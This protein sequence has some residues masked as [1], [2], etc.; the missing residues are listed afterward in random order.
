MTKKILKKICAGT[1]LDVND[2]TPDEKKELY[3]HLLTYGMPMS[4]SY[5]RLFEIGFRPW[6]IMGVSRIRD[7]FLATNTCCLDDNGTEDHGSRGYGY[8]L[9]LSDSYDDSKFYDMVTDLKMGA[10]LCDYMAEKGMDSQMTVRTRFKANDWKPWEL[11]G[12]KSILE[13][14]Y[15]E[16]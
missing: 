14:L 11:K 6:Q 4:T 7:E 2:M 13:E 9:T 8:V 3:S 5:H 12:I 16:D 10:K 1:A 15:G